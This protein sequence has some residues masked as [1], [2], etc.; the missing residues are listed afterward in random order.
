MKLVLLG[1]PG[2][3]KGTQAKYIMEKYNIPHISTGDI[4]RKHIAGKTV[5]GSLAKDY[6]DNGRLVPDDLTIRMVLERLKERDCQGGF[7]LDGFPRTTVQADAL[8]EALRR[9]G[10][11]LDRVIYIYVPED[12]IL[13]RSSGRRVCPNCGET[14]HIKFKPSRNADNCDNCGA[15]LIQREDDKEETIKR[16]L[17]VYEAQT[18]PIVE[19]YE[20]KGLLSM[21]DGTYS[22]DSV[23]DHICMALDYRLIGKSV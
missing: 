23:F 8:E 20:K 14:F 21:I 13:E 22:I 6:M 7:L 17:A 9:E 12:I 4:F 16:R 11:S 10:K 19:F 15:A 18:L 5:L 3:G 1:Q 2:V